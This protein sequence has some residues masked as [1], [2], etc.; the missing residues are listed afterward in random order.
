MASLFANTASNAAGSPAR[1]P[2]HMSSTGDWIPDDEG[3]VCNRCF[4]QVKPGLFTSGKH[5]CRR[6]G[7]MVC[8]KC[9]QH[10]I[11]L[12]RLGQGAE[13]VRI[14]DHCCAHEARRTACLSQYIPKLMQGSVFIKYPGQDSTGM[15]KAHPRIV[16]LSSDQTSF[17]WHKQGDNNPKEAACIVVNEVTGIMPNLTSQKARRI[18]KQSGKANCCFSVVAASR[19]L[20]LECGS[21]EERDAWIKCFGE[22]VQYAKLETPE[23]MRIKSQQE[24]NK[25]AAREEAQKERQER[26][27]HRNELRKKYANN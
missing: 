23:V 3:D 11:S 8:G 24:L 14:C 16:R 12:A 2:G 20:D 4:K 19:S 17:V 13:P 25:Q 15:G 21:P 6:C 10:K 5:H 1:S 22:F 9:S 18:V 27:R 7:Q 26:Q